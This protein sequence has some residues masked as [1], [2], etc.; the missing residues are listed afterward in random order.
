[1]VLRDRD[2]APIAWLSAAV[3]VVSLA[4]VLAG[5]RAERRRLVAPAPQA[6]RT[7]A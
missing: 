4:I 3:L 2:F 7:H 5:I 6:G 1:L